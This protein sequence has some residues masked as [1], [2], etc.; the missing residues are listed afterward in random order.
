MIKVG[1]SG[2][3]FDD[4][5]GP[6]YPANIRKQDMLSYYEKEIGLKILEVNSTYYALP[7][8]KSM[9]TMSRKTSPEFEFVVKAHKAM[10]HEIKEKGS[11]RLID[12]KDVFEKFKYSIDPLKSEGKL[13]CVLAQFPYSFYSNKNNF[14]YL[15]VFKERMGDIKLVVEFRNKYWHKDNVVEFLSDNDLGYCVV[16]EPKLSG[17]MPFV[18]LATTDIGYFR[19]HGRNKNWF[20]VP[21]SVRYD[22][23]YSEEELLEFIG[24]INKIAVDTSITLVFFNNC[25]AG[26]AVKNAI[27]LIKMLP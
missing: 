19:L 15:K 11:N 9:E 4:W 10:T 3:S 22:Y 2:F 1:T 12:N 20:N 23:L 8:Q 21:T 6:V 7:S 13:K 25:H 27:M 18:P 24:P 16:D 17:L 26:S 14:E 5:K